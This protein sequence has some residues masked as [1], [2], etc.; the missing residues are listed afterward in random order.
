MWALR[1]DIMDA[2][3]QDDVAPEDTEERLERFDKAWKVVNRALT[4]S[5]RLSALKEKNEKS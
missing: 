3:F 2:S 1:S 4:T 5:Q